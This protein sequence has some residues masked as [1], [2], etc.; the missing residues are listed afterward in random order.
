MVMKHSEKLEWSI[1]PCAYEAHLIRRHNNAYFAAPRRFVSAEEL[2][3]A[4]R[5][6]NRDLTAAKERFE[7]LLRDIASTRGRHFT[8]GDAIE[9]RARLEEFVRFSMGI[10]G[11]AKWLASNIDKLRDT[12]IIVLRNAFSNDKDTLEHIERAELSYEDSMRRFA[13]PVFAQLLRENSPIPP[14]E[15]LS[16]ILSEDPVSISLFIKL[17]PENSKPQV[18]VDLLSMMK[19]ALENGYIDPRFQEKVSAIEGS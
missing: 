7:D 1:E 10:G 3:E 5:I 6:D 15:T 13:I 17:M 18:R 4:K 9:L 14:E 2:E 8:S 11:R 16:T 19:T 12:V